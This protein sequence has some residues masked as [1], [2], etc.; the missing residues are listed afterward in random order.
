MT[1][2]FRLFFH[3][4]DNPD[5]DPVMEF[6]K[7]LTETGPKNIITMVIAHNGGKYGQHLFCEIISLKKFPHQK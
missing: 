3:G 4:F 7:F 5:A 2:R 1:C 6:L